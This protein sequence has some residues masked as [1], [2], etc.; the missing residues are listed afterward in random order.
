MQNFHTL[1]VKRLHNPACYD[2]PVNQVHLVETHI[3]WVFLAG[4]FV[5]KLKKPVNFGFLDFSTL[6]KRHHYCLEELRLNQ[7][8]A[9]ELYLDVVSIGGSPEKPVVGGTPAIDYLVKMKRF[10]RQ[11]ELDLL[12]QQNQL[13]PYMIE[14]FAE[15]L[16]DLHQQAPRIN[17]NQSF[18]SLESVQSPVQENFD[19][20]RPLLP[21][22]VHQQQL[23]E[24]E[25]WS[26]SSFDKL[27][28][29][30]LQRK[31]EGFIRECHGDVHLANML[32][33]NEQPVLFDCIEF[34][35]NFRCI[36]V[37][38][39]CAFLLMDLD[40]RGAESL[41]WQFLNR[42]LHQTGD[43]Q[44]LPL[45]N[46]YKSYRALVRAKVICLRLNQPG[47][48]D[49]ER[50]L[51]N[52]LLQSYLDLAGSYSQS[53]KA[54]LII[55]HGFSGSGK[56]TFINQLV[57]LYGAVSILSDIE[58]KRIHGLEATAQSNSEV[59]AGMYTEQASQQ[60]YNR[61]LSLSETLL[62]SGF[63]V[64][65]DAT[66]LRLQQRRQMQQLA[67]RLE[68]PFIIL[69]FPLKKEELLRRVA[70]R[71]RQSGQVSEAT[72]EVLNKQWEQEP[73]LTTLENQACIKVHPDSSPEFI[74]DLINMSDTV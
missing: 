71:S 58:R 48:S 5:Y 43:Y 49:I 27:R 9:S 38:N 51:D 2:H 11:N 54:P 19:Q 25:S 56:S 65:V 23:T 26:Q 39:D 62:K 41:S 29:L 10:S 37:I 21:D 36:D 22:P 18:G 74:V 70:S 68:S 59:D 57:P 20:I 32:W 53:K 64:I 30:M 7:R 4:N 35:D 55:S 12:L 69:D 52:G 44:A 31:G 47:L 63:P 14:Q 16:A 42:Y 72:S 13:T 24:L 61:I 6:S 3:S 46:Y 28:N 66:F 34:N 67:S 45:L 8:F 17:S 15:Y 40:D 73:P 33:L 50:K 1:L 60:V